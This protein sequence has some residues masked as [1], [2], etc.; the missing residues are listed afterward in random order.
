MFGLGPVFQSLYP[1]SAVP[2]GAGSSR[3]AFE[4]DGGQCGN[5]CEGGS[6]KS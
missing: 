1:E 3:V 5:A 4:L 6:R 2:S